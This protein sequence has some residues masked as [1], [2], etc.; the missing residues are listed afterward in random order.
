MDDIGDFRPG[1]KAMKELDIKSPLKD[2]GFKKSEI[3]KVACEMNILLGT[4]RLLPACF[5]GFPM[6]KRLHMKN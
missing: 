1:M 6:E 4:G 3:R 5:P 2:A